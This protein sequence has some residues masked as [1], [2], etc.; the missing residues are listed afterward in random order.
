MMAKV[1][2]KIIGRNKI[3]HKLW[4]KTKSGGKTPAGKKIGEQWLTEP[5]E[6]RKISNNEWYNWIGIFLCLSFVRFQGGKNVNQPEEREKGSWQFRIEY[7]MPKKQWDC[8]LYK[9]H[10]MRNVLIRFLTP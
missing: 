8:S 10:L 5:A 6:T 9:V 1:T 4:G 2:R 7:Q 3:T